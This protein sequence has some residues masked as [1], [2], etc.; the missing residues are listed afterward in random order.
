MGFRFLD[1]HYFCG[2]IPE[3]SGTSTTG[4]GRAVDTS[5]AVDTLG[6]R[7]YLAS[8]GPQLTQ[9]AE[10]GTRVQDTLGT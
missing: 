9:P 1:K 10:I 4:G 8:V 3:L 7:R 2:V 5:G 6:G